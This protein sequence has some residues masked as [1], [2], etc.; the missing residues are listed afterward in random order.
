MKNQHN[1]LKIIIIFHFIAH[2]FFLNFAI[3]RLG[4]YIKIEL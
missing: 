1:Y 3:V 2:K 4:Q